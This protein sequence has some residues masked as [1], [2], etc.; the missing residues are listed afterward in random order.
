MFAGILDFFSGILLNDMAWLALGKAFALPMRGTR[1]LL[2]APVLPPGRFSFHSADCEQEESRAQQQL[3]K[4]KVQEERVPREPGRTVVWVR[5]FGH[6][7][8]STHGLWRST[9]S[10]CFF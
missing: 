6:S 2:S 5:V 9:F 8:P 7:A 3:W 4:E 10:I 1:L